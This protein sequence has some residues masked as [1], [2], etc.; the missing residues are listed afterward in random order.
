MQEHLD[1]V[2]KLKKTKLSLKDMKSTRKMGQ[3]FYYYLIA[4]ERRYRAHLLLYEHGCTKCR[5]AGQ[6]SKH[7]CY[8]H[9]MGSDNLM[10]ARV[11]VKIKP[12]VAKS[13]Q[14]RENNHRRPPDHEEAY[15]YAEMLACL[16]LDNS[17]YSLKEFAEYVGVGTEKAR[18]RLNFT[19][20]P[21]EIRVLVEDG[22]ISMSHALELRRLIDLGGNSSFL[23]AK[24]IEYLLT[25]PR[26]K[27]RLDD[28]RARITQIIEGLDQTSLFEEELLTKKDRRS[29]VAAHLIPVLATQKGYLDHVD[30][31]IQSG[32][33]GKGK[34]FSGK[35]P[36]R[37]V[38]FIIRNVEK[39]V[40]GFRLT[41]RQNLA[42]AVLDLEQP[43]KRK[44]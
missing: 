44:P 35:S 4:G 42:L 17:K 26:S 34:L 20:L 31:L 15:A 12:L 9:H 7:G 5:E 2:N 40:P 6:T 23:V 43:Q 13:I 38:E 3:T 1:F 18:R 36:G 32:Y 41:K 24:Q 11:C 8:R 33:V 30:R 27:S 19:E 29:V 10:D 37:W 39:I 16:R 21:E 28:F 22:F 14:F 25:T